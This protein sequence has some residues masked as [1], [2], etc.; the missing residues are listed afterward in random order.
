MGSGLVTTFVTAAEDISGGGI[1]VMV[2][3]AGRVAGSVVGALWSWAPSAFR[4]TSIT[5]LRG[6]FPG[7]AVTTRASGMPQVMPLA[8]GSVW[9]RGVEV[10]KDCAFLPGGSN[11][12]GVP[13]LSLASDC[14]TGL[15]G[16]AAPK[17][18]LVCCC[19]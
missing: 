8:A 10:A 1:G 17:T 2:R 6:T 7:S 14:T 19:P 15:G 11:G 3:P 16:V 4:D 5:L 18:E 12:L 9:M 13:M